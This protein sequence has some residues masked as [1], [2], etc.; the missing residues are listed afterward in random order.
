MDSGFGALELAIRVA[1]LVHQLLDRV[2]IKYLVDQGRRAMD[3]VVLNLA[4]GRGRRGADRARFYR[5]AYASAQETVAV[6]RLVTMRRDVNVDEVLA[7]L[8]RL[9]AVTWVLHRR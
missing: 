8:D 5:T 6:V 2:D 3:S 1:R 9:C 7:A 4:E